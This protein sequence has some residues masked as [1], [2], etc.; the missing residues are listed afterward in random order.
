MDLQWILIAMASGVEVALD[1]PQSSDAVDCPSFQ[2]ARAELRA[3]RSDAVARCATSSC[4]AGR[5]WTGGMSGHAG[6][7]AKVQAAGALIHIGSVVGNTSTVVA[8]V[9][10]SAGHTCSYADRDP[11]ATRQKRASWTGESGK[12]GD[13]VDALSRPSCQASLLRTCIRLSRLGCCRG[14]PGSRAGRPVSNSARRSLDL[15]VDKRGQ[16]DGSMYTLRDAMAAVEVQPGDGAVGG[17]YWEVDDAEDARVVGP[18]GDNASHCL[19]LP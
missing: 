6:Y 19:A 7:R 2:L 12:W 10:K 9:A 8:F 13:T 16:W 4:S 11:R 17:R 5:S 1:A 18:G 14:L 15:A 3:A